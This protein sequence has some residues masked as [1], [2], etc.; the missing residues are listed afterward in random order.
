MQKAETLSIHQLIAYQ[1]AILVHKIVKS[2]QPKYI[3]NK[4]KPKSSIISLRGNEGLVKIPNYKLSISREGFIFR[5]GTLYNLL[6]ETLRAE[7]N[8]VIFKR[9]LKEWVQENI[10]IKP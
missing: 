1:T 3:A 9:K 8:I 10:P 6:G 5:G 2:G 4:L 7:E